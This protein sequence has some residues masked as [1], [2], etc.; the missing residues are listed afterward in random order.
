ME[1]EARPL[2]PCS[3]EPLLLN[4]FQT[5][6]GKGCGLFLWRRLSMHRFPKT[7]SRKSSQEEGSDFSFRSLWSSANRLFLPSLNL[8]VFL[9]AGGFQRP[10]LVRWTEWVFLCLIGH[11]CRS[12]C[13]AEGKEILRNGSGSGIRGKAGADKGKDSCRVTS[14][15]GTHP[16]HQI[17]MGSGTRGMPHHKNLRLLEVF[18]YPTSSPPQVR[19]DLWPLTSICQSCDWQLYRGEKS[20]RI[21]PSS[22]TE[23]FHT[24]S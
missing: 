19:F 21:F 1:K 23:C 22:K 4:I 17:Q 2:R 14:V 11:M 12:K 6:H 18:K 13:C 5:A 10:L 8:S 24:F 9:C 16:S 7:A 15:F 3:F 20:C